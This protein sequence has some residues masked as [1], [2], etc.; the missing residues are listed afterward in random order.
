MHID[1]SFTNGTPP[2]SMGMETVGATPLE[3][4]V[5]RGGK[6]SRQKALRMYLQTLDFAFRGVSNRVTGLID[7]A[8]VGNSYVGSVKK[9]GDFVEWGFIFDK[10]NVVIYD[11]TVQTINEKLFV[12]DSLRVASNNVLR[13][14]WIKDILEGSSENIQANAVAAIEVVSEYVADYDL[15]WGDGV[16]SLL[17]STGKRTTLDKVKSDDTYSVLKLVNILVPKGEHKGVF[18]INCFGFSEVM[19][20]AMLRLIWVM[21]GDTFVFLYNCGEYPGIKRELVTLPNFLIKEG[22]VG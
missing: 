7:I 10:T 12:A 17:D 16:L 6:T 1:F 21:Q 2:V 22:A 5:P 19:L 20:K 3:I 18:F 13:P 15:Y 8:G 11:I 14:A 4:V 9:V